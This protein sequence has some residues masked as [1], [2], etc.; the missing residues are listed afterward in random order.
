MHHPLSILKVLLL[1]FG[2]ALNTQAKFSWS[3][4]KKKDDQTIHGCDV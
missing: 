3:G 1:E 4:K 2:F